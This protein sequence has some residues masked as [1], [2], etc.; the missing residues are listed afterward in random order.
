MILSNTVR[1]YCTPKQLRDIANLMEASI[2]TKRLGDDYTAYTIGNGAQSLRF[3]ADQT[4]YYKY[5]SKQEDQ[6]WI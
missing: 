3:V 4:E 5:V 2:P 1:V 6:E